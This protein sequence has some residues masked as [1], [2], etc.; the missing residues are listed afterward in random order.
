MTKFLNKE[1]NRRNDKIEI[2][3]RQD[4]RKH[5]TIPIIIQVM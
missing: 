2:K 1:G 3:D 5:V 4:K